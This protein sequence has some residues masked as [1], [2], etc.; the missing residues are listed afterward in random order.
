M[1]LTLLILGLA[2]AS[3]SVIL[4]VTV[5][6]MRN[7]SGVVR[8]ALHSSS[9]TFPA[10]VPAFGII[11]ETSGQTASA[12]FEVPVGDYAVSVHH[13]ENENSVFETAIFGIPRE[14]FGSSTR[15]RRLGPPR[16]SDSVF[17]LEEDHT[18]RIALNYLL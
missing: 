18:V 5:T 15:V 16:Y 3:D 4:D 1:A 12:R 7:D 2:S 10:A 13:D 14:G 11:A 17:Y 9:S 8:V 6:G